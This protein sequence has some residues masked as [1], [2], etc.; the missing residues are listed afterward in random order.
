MHR[1]ID[2]FKKNVIFKE[3]SIFLNKIENIIPFRNPNLIFY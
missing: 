1:K 2:F 3:K